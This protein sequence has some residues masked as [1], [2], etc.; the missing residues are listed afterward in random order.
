MEA[1]LPT[2][3]AQC[4]GVCPLIASFL[5]TSAPRLSRSLVGS[6]LQGQTIT[7]TVHQAAYQAGMESIGVRLKGGLRYLE[8]R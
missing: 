4:S 7:A 8:E 2:R 5:F 1:L 3:S 6:V